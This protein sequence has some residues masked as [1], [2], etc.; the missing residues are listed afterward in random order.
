MPL[1]TIFQLYHGG[2]F[3][4]WRK[5]GYHEKT[6]NLSQ[7]TDKLYHIKLYRVHLAMSEFELT[8]LVVIGTDC[9]GSCKSNHHTITTMMDPCIVQCYGISGLGARPSVTYQNDTFTLTSS[10]IFPF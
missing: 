7:V 1:S 8:T 10:N 3:Y 2:H 6:T 4:W 9:T 5:P